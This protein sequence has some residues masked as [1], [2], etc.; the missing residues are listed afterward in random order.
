MVV[1]NV[2]HLTLT[3]TE[4]C[5]GSHRRFSYRERQRVHGLHCALC[6][7]PSAPSGLPYRSNPPSRRRHSGSN[8]GGSGTPRSTRSTALLQ[9]RMSWRWVTSS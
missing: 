2:S 9:F 7:F 3:Q 5:F 4:V 8:H 1:S 6:T